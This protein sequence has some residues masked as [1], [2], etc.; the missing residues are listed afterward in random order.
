MKNDT[1]LSF[2]AALAGAAIW[3]AIS[4]ATGRKEA[5]DS[6]A[7]FA[8]GIPAVCVVSVVLAYLR[9]VR[10]WRWGV[11][12]MAGQFAWMLFTQGPG[13]LLPLGIVAFAILSIPS[14]IAAWLAAAVARR[15]AARSEDAE[16]PE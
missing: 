11:L 3:I 2:V 1:P 12:P 8:F 10:T 13:N 9:P 6:G 16:A 5:W 14:L 7:Y 4:I 15:Y